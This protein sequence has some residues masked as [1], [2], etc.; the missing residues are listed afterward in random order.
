MPSFKCRDIGMD[1]D[2]ETTAATETELMKNIA[3]HALTAH[4]M[5]SIPPDILAKIKAA[6]GK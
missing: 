1:C 5:I 6:I 2:F 4:K 3:T